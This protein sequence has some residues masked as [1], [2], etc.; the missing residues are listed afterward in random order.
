MGGK[1]RTRRE[2]EPLMTQIHDLGRTGKR[3]RK[4]IFCMNNRNGTG[5]QNWDIT[6]NISEN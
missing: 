5:K 2:Q 3:K 4:W 6:P 1:E